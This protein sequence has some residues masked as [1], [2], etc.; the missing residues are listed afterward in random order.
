MIRRSVPL[1]AHVRFI[2]LMLVMVVVAT[3]C[4]RQKNKNPEEGMP[5]DQLYQKAHTQ[6]QTS[7]WAGA[8]GSFKRLI[9]QYP[10]GQYTEQAMI[11]SAY[12]QYKAGKHD[13]AVSSIDRFIRTYP[14]HRNIAYMYYL[15]GLS[16]SNRD[17]VFLRR[18]WS[19]D[20]SRRDLSTPQQAYADFNIVA[21]RYPNSRY[22][23]DAR[24]R[25]IALRNV[26]AQHE[27][28][29]ALYYL[30]RNAWVSAAGRASYLLETYPQ[31]AYQYDAVAV[32]ADAYT[33]LG[34][35]PLADDARRVLELND[36][37]HPWLTGHWPQYPWMIRKLN[38]FA[39][40]KSAS[41]GQ[42]NSQM[43]N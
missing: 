23:A 19:L 16:N 26:F 38:P 25:M 40:E 11:E 2:A 5:V 34:N 22:A 13:D 35:K 21:E 9:A 32:L 1:S 36:P 28:D 7:N 6:M 18:V 43:A 12:A 3:G 4:H 17:T 24:Q 29:N 37:K 20:P 42:S 10:Y 14:T 41:T 30:R 39:G 31:S 15:R 33:H 27:L 8:E